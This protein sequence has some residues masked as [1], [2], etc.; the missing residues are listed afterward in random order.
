MTLTERIVATVEKPA[1]AG[2]RGG[3]GDYIT[4]N[5]GVRS[6]TVHPRRPEGARLLREL[7]TGADV[8]YANR[9]PGYLSSIGF[10]AEE[11]AAVSDLDYARSVAG[12][13]EEHAYPDPET[14]TADT[15]LGAYQGVTD[16]VRMSE[17]PGPYRHI[18]VPRGASRPAWL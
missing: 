8:F 13:G 15:P 5:V 12:T 10:S 4:A 6:S 18:L 1:E 16:Q 3:A 11:A 9:R 17:T 2:R 7:L 14:F